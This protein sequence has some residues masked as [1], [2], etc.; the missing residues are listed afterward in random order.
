M[1]AQQTGGVQSMFENLR[2]NT[3][4]VA[5]SHTETHLAL[6]NYVVTHLEKLHEEIK[7]HQKEVASAGHKGGKSVSKSRELT[8]AH[9]DKL[10]Q[11]V[12]NFDA[13]GANNTALKDPADD[14]YIVRRGVLHRLNKQV[15]EENS[16]RQELLGV[17][18]NFASFEARI[19]Q[20]M[21]NAMNA[22]YQAITTQADKTK[23]IYGDIFQA[24]QSV[25]PD[26]E[27]NAFVT[28]YGNVLIDPKQPNRNLNDIHFANTDHKATAP[29]IEGALQ[30]KGT[31]LKSYNNGY[32]VV[33]PSKYLHEF[34]DNDNFHR[35]P[36]PEMSLYL[37]ECTIGRLS[38]SPEAKFNIS[39]KDANKNRTLSRE[40]E[41]CFKAT[42]HEEAKKWYDI[43]IECV[44]V[45]TNETPLPSPSNTRASTF[46]SVDQ[47]A[48]APPASTT[49]QETGIAKPV[50]PAPVPTKTA[51]AGAVKA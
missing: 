4:A 50:E 33:T 13:V 23:S 21:Q 38:Q 40:H 37:P 51:D 42:T 10:A 9:I 8:K 28:R 24:V 29:L 43:L 27:W 47:A 26:Y 41:F 20:T 15:N 30:R 17:Q 5:H 18:S 34:K 16:Y 46:A 32:Y 11:Q 22:F 19:I 3:A 1:Y 7:Q 2:A 14:P 35:D 25:A 48:T 44:G 31:I 49:A 12:G 36:Q 45:K 39:G 6:R